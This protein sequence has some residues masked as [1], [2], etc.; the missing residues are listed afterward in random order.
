LCLP[1]GN[2]LSASCGTMNGRKSE[3]NLIEGA[4]YSQ[5]QLH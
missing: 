4:E 1:T 3:F 2:D 5:K